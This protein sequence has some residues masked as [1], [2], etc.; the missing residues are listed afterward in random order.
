MSKSAIAPTGITGT[1][2]DGRT[3]EVDH[4]AK[5]RDLLR[6]QRQAGSKNQESVIY[7]LVADMAVLDGQPITFEDV[8]DLEIE[9]FSTLMAAVQGN[10]QG[11]SNSQPDKAS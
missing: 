11:E 1:L 6:A 10:N 5:A 8:M 2:T 4:K 3:F 7:Y 9:D